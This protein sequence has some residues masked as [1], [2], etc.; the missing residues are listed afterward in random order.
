[1]SYDRVW[2]PCVG[3][4]QLSFNAVRAMPYGMSTNLQRFLEHLR[5]T[6]APR[7]VGS[8]WRI[9]HAFAAF[10]GNIESQPSQYDVERFLARPLK[11]G[12]ARSAAT[13]NQELA[14]I[15]AFATFL[16]KT[17]DWGSDP[18]KDI[19]FAKE[20]NRDPVF[21]MAG[22]LRRLFEIAGN[23]ADTTIRAR[24]LAIIAVLSQAGLRVHELVSINVEQVDLDTNTLLA[25]SGKGGTCA[26]LPLSIETA[27]LLRA[28]LAERS[29][30]AM[31]SESALFVSR[32]GWRMSIRCVERT[33]ERLRR[34]MGSQKQFSPHS[35]RHTMATLELYF[36]SD[37][38]TVGELLRH[39]SLDTTRRYVHLLD[40][41]RRDAVT[42]LAKTIPLS[43][44]PAIPMTRLVGAGIR[45]VNLNAQPELVENPT[46]KVIDD[47][48]NLDD[49]A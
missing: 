42:R 4:P 48:Q 7:T 8:Y 37:L 47:H 26:E 9:V 34:K 36:G 21:L 1:M 41:R 40:E 45:Q 5:G 19:D 6:R 15:M 35:L 46:K 10:I 32:R 2:F 18:T 22:E 14:A 23:E 38:A 11:C 31:E 30:M 43:V 12:R 39:A 49:A 17:G 29:S 13:R 3:E 28:W 16:R 24:D 20:P 33:I 44:L 25:V 27:L